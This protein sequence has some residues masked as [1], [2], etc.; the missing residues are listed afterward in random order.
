MNS[1][2]YTADAIKICDGSQ[3]DW[4]IEGSLAAQYGRDID[5]I[6]RGL[7]A[8]KLANVSF[9]YFIDRYLK[10]DKSVPFDPIVDTI[11]R[12]V[13]KRWVRDSQKR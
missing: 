4:V 8:C 5:F 6:K 10:K 3:F 13:Q 9:D 12:D 2:E 7:E 11:S 1:D